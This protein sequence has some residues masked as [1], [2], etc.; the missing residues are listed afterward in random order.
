MTVA[1]PICPRSAE[2]ATRSYV[3]P[4]SKQENAY[5]LVV[6]GSGAVGQTAAY[7]GRKRGLRVLVVE[8]RD[9]GGTCPNRGCDAKKPYVHAAAV[10]HAVQ[11][12]Q[13]AGTGLVGELSMSWAKTAAFKKA[14]TDPVDALTLDDLEAA[15]IGVFRGTAAFTGPDTLRL[16]D[17]REVE[18]EMVVI[19]T[20]E[21]PRAMDAP[22]GDLAIDSDAFL[23]LD[24]L[25]P[26]VVF[27]G[28]GYIGM[29]FACAAAL[30]GREVTVVASGEHPLNGFDADAVAVLEAALPTLGPHG[31][32]LLPGARATKLERTGDG[33][34]VFTDADT[35]AAVGDL[36]VNATGRVA[37]I[38]GM[39]LDAAGVESSP[40]G[41]RVDDT[42]RC[43]GNPRVWA[44]GDVADTGRPSL[45]PTAV[46]DA[47]QLVKNLA[48][49]ADGREPEP[50]ATHPPATVAF[51]V[52]TL[53]SVGMT[54]A[55]ARDVHG[56]GV[57]V[58]TGDLTTKKFYRQL[59]VEHAYYK[60]VF[61]T[62]R[63]LLGAHLAGPESEEVIN[64]FAL[65]LDRC[66]SETE[67]CDAVLTY[68]TV[69]MAMQ[70]A[71]RKGASR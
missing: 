44:G 51:T 6:L 57:L 56:D 5:G 12:L 42:L 71:F 62:D 49:V 66:C 64:V 16:S 10:L 1:G 36:V 2:S 20:G 47:R 53:A 45:I 52:P 7:D 31:V 4:V 15:G 28:A 61:D 29:E 26:R 34:A 32:R 41:V 24:D 69:A 55:Q 19:A 40:R 60:L 37:S 18:A 39:N 9:L 58:S 25:P 70:S 3:P 23:D 11:R 67:L 27:I 38:D 21:R 50:V 59:G 46:A 13:A 17:G 63:R 35:P 8:S 68:P 48:A 43:P 33:I 54:E 30:A 14:F 65:A 22:G